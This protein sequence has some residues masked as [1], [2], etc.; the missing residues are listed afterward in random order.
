MCI[1]FISSKQLIN[2]GYRLIVASNREE[3][4]NRPTLP[5]NYWTDDQNVIGGK[6]KFY[7]YRE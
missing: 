5:A 3:N 2:G 4:Y 6:N 1:L 7:S